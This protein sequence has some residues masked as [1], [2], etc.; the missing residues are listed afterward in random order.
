LAPVSLTLKG[1]ILHTLTSES[2]E[3]VK[4]CLFKEVKV[5][6]NITFNNDKN[7]PIT[8]DETL[9]VT[10]LVYFKEAL[11]KQEFE[12]CAELIKAAKRFGAQQ[13]EISDVIA[14]YARGVEGGRQ[15]EADQVG[16]RLQS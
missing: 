10:A 3:G 13:A 2:K 7:N 16:G 9:K 12:E 4:C 14:E 1:V 15:D 5:K 8:R 6:S 11:V